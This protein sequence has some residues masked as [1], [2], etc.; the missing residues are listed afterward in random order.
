MNDRVS[1]RCHLLDQDQPSDVLETVASDE[2]LGP[3]TGKLPVAFGLW[4]RASKSDFASR[5]GPWSDVPYNALMPPS[6]TSWASASHRPLLAA[7]TQEHRIFCRIFCI[8]ETPNKVGIR[9][10]I[11]AELRVS[12]YLSDVVQ[13]LGF[14]LQNKIEDRPFY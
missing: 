7:A 9:K 13:P 11:E 8:F 4:R 5:Q 3:G 10:L 2:M 12:Y 1:R 6:A 14:V